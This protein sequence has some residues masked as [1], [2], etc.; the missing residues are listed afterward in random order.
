[1]TPQQETFR[2]MHY[3]SHAMTGQFKAASFAGVTLIHVVAASSPW[4]FS[5]QGLTAFFALL[6]ATGQLGINLAFHRMLSHRSFRAA[7]IVERCLAVLGTLALQI[8][9][10]SWV[11]NHRYHHKEADRPLD[12]HTPFAGFAWAHFFW[13]FYS[14]PELPDLRNRAR[15]A[16][17]LAADPFYRNLERHFLALNGL[18]FTALFLVG[19][20]AGGPILGASLF[21]WGGCLRVVAIWHMTFIVNSVNH[22][23]GYR[24]YETADNSRNN[25][26]VS[27]VAF[28]EGWH[29]NHHAEPRSAAHGHTRFE[30]DICYLIIRAMEFTGFFRDVIRPRC[31]RLPPQRDS[32]G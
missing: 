26:W 1:M 28:G 30:V 17:E 16:P 3:R 22:L 18:L 2:F 15:Y 21:V 20:L 13:T 5:W 7:R 8:G 24:S 29:N 12:P 19:W 10:I 25:L 32:G 6:V 9:P 23:W 14:H 11:G 31:W 27:L 4:F